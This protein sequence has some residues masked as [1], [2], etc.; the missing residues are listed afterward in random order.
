MGDDQ[1]SKEKSFWTTLP[2]I[3]TGLAAVITAV[4][5]LLAVLAT[6][7]VIGGKSEPT[8]VPTAAESQVK[9]L[10]VVQTT[11]ESGA[12]NVD[13]SLDEIV[14]A[15]S[16]AVKQNS[17]SFVATAEG[18]TPEM[19]GDPYFPDNK[20]CVLPVRL[21]PGVAYS[22]GVNSDQHTGFK[23]AQ[24]PS[25]TVIPYVLTFSTGQ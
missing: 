4:G 3:L 9:G 8:P 24:D 23:G 10:R 20:T 21:E 18:E 7:G 19:L 17:W 6:G 14:I 2:G 15:F 16:D 13:P 25:I 5:G 22:L 1:D 12:A 11:P